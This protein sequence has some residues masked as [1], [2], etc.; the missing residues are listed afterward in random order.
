ME[1]IDAKSFAS[2]WKPGTPGTVLLDVREHEEI[3]VAAVPGATHIPMG[4]IP[5]RLAELDRE[6]EIVVMCHHGMRS[7]RVATFLQGQGYSHVKNLSG[8]IDAWSNSV[9]PRVPKY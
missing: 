8:G 5:T 3:E 2:R 4:E 7:L 9:D 1:Q 6:A